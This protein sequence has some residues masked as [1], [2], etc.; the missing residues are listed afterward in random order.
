MHTSFAYVRR[1][2]E[3]RFRPNHSW[4]RIYGTCSCDASQHACLRHEARKAQILD[5]QE[6]PCDGL[7]ASFCT[8]IS[9]ASEPPML[10]RSSPSML[11]VYLAALLLLLSASTQAAAASGRIVLYSVKSLVT[12]RIDP[13]ISPG[14]VSQQL[15]QPT[16]A[17][18]APYLSD[19]LSFFQLAHHRRLERL[20]PDV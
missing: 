18:A 1:C 11:R 2:M 10:Q 16:L 12:A 4:S 5:P 8:F 3:S 14:K 20:Q 19:L 7:F 13:L 9:R 15:V 6:L 17:P